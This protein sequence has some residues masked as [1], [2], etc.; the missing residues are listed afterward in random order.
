MASNNVVVFKNFGVPKNPGI[1]YRL[2]CMTGDKKGEVYYLR[3]NRVVMGRADECDIQVLDAKSSR[4]HAELT[5]MG[6]GFFITDLGSQNGVVVNDVKVKQHALNHGD[7]VV[8]GQTVFKYGRIEV[9]DDA[10]DV[11]AG[12]GPRIDQIDDQDD[13]KVNIGKGRMM[14]IVGVLLAVY[15]V[16]GDQNSEREVKYKSATYRVSEVNDTFSRI[17]DK[18]DREQDKSKQEKVDAIFFRGLRELREENYYRAINEFNLALILDP[19]NGRAQFYLDKTKQLL[20]QEVS[21]RFIV[22]LKEVNALRYKNAIIT[23][24]SIIR[25]LQT[26]PEDERYKTAEG[27]VHEMEKKLGL[28]ENEI[29]CL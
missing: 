21:E 28:E 9:R 4:E 22:A 24:C 15:L 25:L 16:I 29:K 3:A 12:E 20:D 19:G 1:H 23:Y 2:T 8:I 27:N 18:Q 17:I 26:N 10:D 13:K 11:V 7:T 14:L 6:A 5:R